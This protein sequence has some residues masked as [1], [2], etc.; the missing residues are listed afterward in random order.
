MKELGYN[1]EEAKLERKQKKIL[2]KNLEQE[3]ATATKLDFLLL[4]SHNLKE[5]ESPLSALACQSYKTSEKRDIKY[6][7]RFIAHKLSLNADDID[8]YCYDHKQT[9]A[10]ELGYIYK[11]IWKSHNL[12]AMKPEEEAKILILHYCTK[13]TFRAQDKSNIVTK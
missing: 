11:M 9:D 7:K 12:T 3:I 10:R 1:I 13:G 8:I 6:I 5:N 2:N 4:P